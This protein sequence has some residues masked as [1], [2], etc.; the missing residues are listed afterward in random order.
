MGLEGITKVPFSNFKLTLYEL[1]AMQNADF[2]ECEGHLQIQLSK[3]KN[4]Q[5]NTLCVMSA[6]KTT[7]WVYSAVCKHPKH[8]SPSDSHA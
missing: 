4:S 8:K 3:G 2:L 5:M 6:F 1:E 7:T